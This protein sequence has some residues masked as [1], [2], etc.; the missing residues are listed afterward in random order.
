MKTTDPGIIAPPRNC[1]CGQPGCLTLIEVVHFETHRR[2]VGAFSQFGEIKGPK[3]KLV[4]RPE[5][6]FKRWI[7]QC[8]DCRYNEHQGALAL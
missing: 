3:R 8:V 5:Y 7:V 4:L 2:R 6:T 1:S